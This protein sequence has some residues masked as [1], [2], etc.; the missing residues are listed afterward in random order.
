MKT[1]NPN[2][3]IT[4]G[5]S[6]SSFIGR[7]G[8]LSLVPNE[9]P[10]YIRNILSKDRLSH[11]NI[12]SFDELLAHENFI[13]ENASGY[14]EP[15]LP[16]NLDVLEVQLPIKY[17]LEMMKKTSSR[18]SVG[19]IILEILG[20]PTEDLS[21]KIREI[22]D[23]FT[24]TEISIVFLED[25]ISIG[26]DFIEKIET[27]EYLKTIYI[28]KNTIIEKS[29]KNISFK[30]RESQEEENN[31]ITIFPNKELLVESYFVNNYLNKRL[32]IDQNGCFYSSKQTDVCLGDITNL[33]IT[34]VLRSDY[35][36]KL[37]RLTKDKI[38]VCKDCDFRRVCI[39]F[40][41]PTERSKE[42]WFNQIECSYNPY[43]TKWK[44][45]EDYLNLAECGVI[46]NEKEFSIN[47]EKIAILNKELWGE[48]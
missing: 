44:G 48:E 39:D 9:L 3:F 43:I 38:D 15:E 30:R 26:N 33:D 22:G 37:W 35:L 41:N 19:Q 17:E 2:R 1:L 28:Q 5:Y 24:D 27:I 34:D 6:R 7:D 31:I 45:E 23:A 36:N 14:K 10:S 11:T 32:F 20:Q 29:N 46:S 21:K 4:E 13:V 16:F 18:L 47:H 40:R 25:N 42:E 12:S 8:K